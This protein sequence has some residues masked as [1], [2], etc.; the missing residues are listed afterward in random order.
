MYKLTL[1]RHLVVE[2]KNVKM[3]MWAGPKTPSIENRGSGEVHAKYF[4][5]SLSNPCW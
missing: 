3:N 2:F 1:D 4:G 5:E